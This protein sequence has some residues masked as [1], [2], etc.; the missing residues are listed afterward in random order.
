MFKVSL[1]HCF[2]GDGGSLFSI[3]S[4][5]TAAKYKIPVIF[6]CFV[7]HEYRILKDLWCKGKGVDF[8]TTNFIGLDFTD[9]KLDLAAIAA[10][11]GAR[12]DRCN[13]ADNVR[14][15]LENAL[16][17]QG[18]TMIFMERRK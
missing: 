4:I 16:A 15:V 5:W 14:E 12:I 10:G 13:L 7:N 2:V 6:I 1:I 18:P 3:H 8:S 9:P 17:H 11:F